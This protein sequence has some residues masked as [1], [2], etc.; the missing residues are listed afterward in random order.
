LKRDY[1]V[2]LRATGKERWTRIQSPQKN[3]NPAGTTFNKRALVP[4]I[5]TRTKALRAENAP[6]MMESI[7]WIVA[8][9]YTEIGMTIRT[10]NFEVRRVVC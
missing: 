8:L 5:G 4:A 1:A 6:K 7:S 2:N 10:I 3:T 9:I